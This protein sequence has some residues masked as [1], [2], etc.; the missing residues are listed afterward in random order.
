[1]VTADNLQ[2][3]THTYY[4]NVYLGKNLY[5]RSSYF[6]KNIFVLHIEYIL[7]KISDLLFNPFISKIIS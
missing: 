3:Y 2:A 4:I 5:W 7:F 1:M 6:L